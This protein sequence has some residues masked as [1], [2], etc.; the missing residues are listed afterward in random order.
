MEE[1]ACAYMIVED[2]DNIFNDR[3]RSMVRTQVNGPCDR[4]FYQSAVYIPSDI[5]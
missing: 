5:M 3:L 2:H 1:R 4:L